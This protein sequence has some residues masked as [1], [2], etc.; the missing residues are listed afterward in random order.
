M[1]ATCPLAFVIKLY[2]IIIFSTLPNRFRNT[3]RVKSISSS[4]EAN[5]I[6]LPYNMPTDTPLD[7]MRLG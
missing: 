3:H 6:F 7:K 4:P 5:A 2:L 1:I